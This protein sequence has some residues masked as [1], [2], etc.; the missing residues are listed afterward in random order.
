MRKVNYAEIISLPF[1]AILIP[2]LTGFADYS[3]LSPGESLSVMIY[4]IV[5]GYC[6]WKG[7]RFISEIFHNHI[8]YTPAAYFKKIIGL[9]A[10]IFTYG[11]LVSLLLCAGRSYFF[12]QAFDWNIFFKTSL[13]ITFVLV[14]LTLLEE[15][16]F[17]LKKREQDNKKVRMLDNA[18]SNAESS[19]LK[20]ELDPHFIFNSLNALSYLIE[21]E[22]EKAIEFN[23][24]L[25]LVYKYILM[26]KHKKQV[27]LEE[28]VEFIHNYFFLLRI[29]HDDKIKLNVCIPAEKYSSSIVLPCALQTLVEN[30][31]KHNSFSDANPLCI[32]ISADEEFIYVK[33][34]IN[35]TLTIN[36]S[37]KIGLSNLRS[38]YKVICNRAVT[39]EEGKEFFIVRLPLLKTA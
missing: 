11:T 3:H 10:A 38:R 30:A 23:K 34:K 16:L 36:G 22:A 28:E 20:N 19:V 32:I 24:K 37:T 12:A 2:L 21:H 33:N 6:I 39:V 5:A 7:G 15:I 4:F 25:A 29:R 17:L 9:T 26:S 27:F 1:F 8:N 14:V 18:L 35:R 13:S 31:I